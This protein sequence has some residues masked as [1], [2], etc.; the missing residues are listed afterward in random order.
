MCDCSPTDAISGV[1]G[2]LVLLG[3]PVLLK[4][5]RCSGDEQHIFDCAVDSFPSIFCDL[6]FSDAAV[7][8][9]GK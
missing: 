6:H 4:E 5:P 3:E 9:D 8:C 2:N 7:F 1:Q